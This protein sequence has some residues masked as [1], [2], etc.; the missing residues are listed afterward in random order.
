MLVQ[1]SPSLL[2]STSY[3]AIDS[4]SRPA[5]DNSTALLCSTAAKLERA[6]TGNTD[7]GALQDVRSPPAPAVIE[8]TR[9]KPADTY[10]S[11]YNKSLPA[12]VVRNIV[13]AELKAIPVMAIPAVGTGVKPIICVA[14]TLATAVVGTGAAILYNA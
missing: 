11:L 6:E 8:P 12:P 5:H 4:S 2:Y 14:V 13:P 1:C 10:T 3:P 7:R 9:V